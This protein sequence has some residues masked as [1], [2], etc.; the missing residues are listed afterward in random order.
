MWE[1]I[2]SVGLTLGD[3]LFICYLIP[4]ADNFDAGGIAY[5]KINDVSFGKSNREKCGG[6]IYA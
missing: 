1:L 3:P 4:G 2:Y 5:Y 6:R